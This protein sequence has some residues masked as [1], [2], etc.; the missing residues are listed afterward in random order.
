MSTQP[1]I[2]ARQIHKRFGNVE[3]LK[4]IDL[5]VET[6]KVVCIIGPS[7]AGKSTFLRCINHLERPDSGYVL[8]GGQLVGYRRAGNRL[9]EVKERVHTVHRLAR[10]LLDFGVEHRGGGLERGLIGHHL[11]VRKNHS[12]GLLNFCPLCESGCCLRDGRGAVAGSLQE[13]RHRWR[14]RS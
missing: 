10:D 14:R 8:V 13:E 2:I 5:D 7:G 4:G 9:H 3:V 12:S 11:S 6:G 1:M